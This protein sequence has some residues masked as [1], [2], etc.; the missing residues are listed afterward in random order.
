MKHLR[1]SAKSGMAAKLARYCGG[2]VSRVKKGMPSRDGSKG[3]ATGGIVSGESDTA[4]DGVSAKRGFAKPGKMKGDGKAKKGGTNVNVI[5]M[6]KEAGAQ[7]PAPPMM[8]PGPPAGG[9]PPGPPPGMPMRAS[10]GGV[11]NGTQWDHGDATKNAQGRAYAN[12]GKVHDDAK[13]DKKMISS[14]IHKHEKK[15]HGGKLTPFKR[16]GGVGK[17]GSGGAL[18]RLAKIKAYGPKAG[19]AESV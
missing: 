16:G 4:V 13:Q 9:P 5:V 7:P 6:P 12:G 15:E 17:T 11:R 19:K 8:P 2:D 14:M 1:A 10:G 3:Y 18:G